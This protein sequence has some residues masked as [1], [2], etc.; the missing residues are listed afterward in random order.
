MAEDLLSLIKSGR[1][2]AG[3]TLHHT[4]PRYTGYASVAED[5][6]RV[7]GRTYN[8]PTGAAKAITSREVDGWLFWKLP[9]GEALDT[10]RTKRPARG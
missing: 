5:G 3:I 8:T 1:L 4:G 9:S 7:G 2:Q 6:L 10:L